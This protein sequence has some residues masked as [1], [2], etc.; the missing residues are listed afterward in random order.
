MYGIDGTIE[1]RK[2]EKEKGI[3]IGGREEGR[4]GNLMSSTYWN[5]REEHPKQFFSLGVG[6]TC[7]CIL[8]LYVLVGIIR[9]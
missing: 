7:A 6:K 3:N 5:E 2:G 4:E 1:R 8:K 9:P